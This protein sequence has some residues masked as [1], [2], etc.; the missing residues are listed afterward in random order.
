MDLINK[1]IKAEIIETKAYSVQ[2]SSNS[3]KLDAMENPYTWPEEIKHLWLQHLKS[4]ELNRY[5]DPNATSVLPALRKVM[6]VPSEMK[7]ILGN[8]SDELIQIIL[9]AL[10]KDS[11]V[12]AP[13]PSFVMYKMIATFLGLKFIGVPL[14]PD[15]SL[16]ET[17]MDIAIKKHKPAVIFIANPNNPTGNI[18][19]REVITKLIKAN[20]SLIILDEA[21]HSFA[22]DSF[23]GDLSKYSNLLVMRTLSK[24]G[25]A[26]IRLGL[27]AG[28]KDWLDQFDKVRLPYNINILSQI[29][30]QFI[31]EQPEILLQQT[32]KIKINRKKL[33]TDLNA[34]DQ[35]KPIESQANF[36]LFK[37]PDADKIHQHLKKNKILVKNL[38]NYHPLLY[39][40]LRVSIG[41]SSENKMFIQALTTTISKDY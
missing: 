16:D 22:N 9:M 28:H 35:I 1:L 11:V 24:M 19:D 23:M 17:T 26:G 6:Q 30:A 32:E 38:S 37:C 8:G 39:N 33:M 21:Y 36:I 2:K 40:C 4:T 5:P 27:L 3:I 14:A 20:S 18:F 34:I 31:L 7:T 15:Y 29:T 25:L 10:P 41:T 13:E 12:L